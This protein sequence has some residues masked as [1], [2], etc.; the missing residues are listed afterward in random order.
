MG[1]VLYVKGDVVF[2]ILALGE[3]SLTDGIVAALP[4]RRCRSVA[5]VAS[6]R[7]RRPTTQLEGARPAAGLP[8]FRPGDAGQA[9]TIRP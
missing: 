8:R 3:T 6:L 9:V 7:V 5:A 4:S 2:Y 1:V